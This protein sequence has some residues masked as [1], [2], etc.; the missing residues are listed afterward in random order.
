MH[1][2]TKRE[3]RKLALDNNKTNLGFP[4]RPPNVTSGQKI[5]IT[6]QMQTTLLLRKM[7]LLIWMHRWL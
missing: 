7:F 4:P 3:A 5:A 2:I 6:T 1:E